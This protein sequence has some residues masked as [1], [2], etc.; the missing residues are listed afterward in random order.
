MTVCYPIC[1]P[2]IM[3]AI[4]GLYQKR[5]WWYCAAGVFL[6][7]AMMFNEVKYLADGCENDEVA[8]FS[9]VRLDALRDG[10]KT[11]FF[12]RGDFRTEIAIL[13]YI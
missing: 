10:G 12:Q 6:G 1:Y 11:R 3:V 4:K 9:S 5:G 13:F 2:E 7:Y 8:Q